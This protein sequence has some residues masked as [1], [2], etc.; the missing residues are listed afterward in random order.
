MFLL[1]LGFFSF[2]NDAQAEEPYFSPYSLTVEGRYIDYL[3]EDINKDGKNDL[4]FFHLCSAGNNVSRTFSI[5][6]QTQNGFSDIAD[7]KF[8]I[9]KEAVVYFVSDVDPNPGKFRTALPQYCQCLFD[10]RRPARP[11]F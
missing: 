4:L 7:Q 9:D 8:E 11:G 3:V 5:F 2:L 6:Y 1:F 10:L